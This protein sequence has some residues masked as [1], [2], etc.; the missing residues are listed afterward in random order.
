VVI[1]LGS[2]GC[3]SV[4]APTESL[5]GTWDA[6]ISIPGASLTLILDE[7][8]VATGTTV[9]TGT[10]RIEAGRSGTLA[11]A[12]TYHRPHVA[13]TLQYDYGSSSAYVATVLD[14]R[15][16]RGTLTDSLGQ[17]SAQSFTRR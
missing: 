8:D 12:G 9:G 14:D 2:I 7:P 1:G 16:M 4:L 17:S 10:Y 13:L 11:V 6:D 15:H 5:Q 3:S